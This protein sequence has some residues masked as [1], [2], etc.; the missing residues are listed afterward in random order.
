MH[1]SLKPDRSLWTVD[2]RCWLFLNDG[3]CFSYKHVVTLDSQV[4]RSNRKGFLILSLWVSSG[5]KPSLTPC[6]SSFSSV[7]RTLG[8]LEAKRRQCRFSSGMMNSSSLLGDKPLGVVWRAAE[9]T[10]SSRMEPRSVFIWGGSHVT[11]CS[12]INSTHTEPE[13]SFEERAVPPYLRGAKDD[14]VV[15]L[16]STGSFFLLSTETDGHWAEAII[17]AK[18]VLVFCD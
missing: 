8:E 16:S 9:G 14:S 15:V 11:T 2:D 6:S 5:L 13:E 3:T 17:H 4:W 10:D 1:F 12:Q 7:S 18:E